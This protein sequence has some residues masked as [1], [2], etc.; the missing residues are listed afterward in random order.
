MTNRAKAANLKYFFLIKDPALKQNQTGRI[1]IER[2]AVKDL[3]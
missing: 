1:N 3:M 2:E